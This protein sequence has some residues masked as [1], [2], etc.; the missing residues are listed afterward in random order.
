M[1]CVEASEVLS[2]PSLEE[3]VAGEGCTKGE[4]KP[5]SGV[6]SRDFRM[7]G[8]FSRVMLSLGLILVSLST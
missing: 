1:G 5:L 8:S 2:A 3:L 4:D 6:V 7:A